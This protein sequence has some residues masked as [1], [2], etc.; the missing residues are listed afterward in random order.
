[1]TYQIYLSQRA[2]RDVD[3]IH[4]WIAQHSPSGANRWYDSFREAMFS[5]ESTAENKGLAPEAREFERPVRQVLFKT[6]K[7]H[8]YRALFVGEGRRI[9]IVT[10]R[11]PGQ[12][13]LSVDEIFRSLDK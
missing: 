6:R 12:P 1:M 5:L 10:V 4:E 3:D 9:Q 11:G 7:G 2:R 8:T 13:L